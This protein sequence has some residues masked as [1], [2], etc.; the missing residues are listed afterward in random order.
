M[1]FSPSMVPASH[2]LV[3]V[4]PLSATDIEEITRLSDIKQ[5]AWDRLQEMEK[6]AFWIGV[7]WKQSSDVFDAKLI[8]ISWKLGWD[9]TTARVFDETEGKLYG[10]RIK[11]EG[12]KT[13][14]A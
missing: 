11:P 14:G 10:M 5:K 2:E 1:K 6:V 7:Q 4:A 3:G 9:N 12:I 8:E 13:S